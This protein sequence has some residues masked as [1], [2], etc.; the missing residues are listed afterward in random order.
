MTHVVICDLENLA[1]L[2]RQH[3][4]PF[5]I[6]ALNAWLAAQGVNERLAIGSDTAF[7]RDFAAPLKASGW[8]VRLAP[9]KHKMLSGHHS[10]NADAAICLE[11]GARVLEDDLKALTLITCDLALLVDIAWH[12]RTVEEIDIPIT[13]LAYPKFKAGR[14]PTDIPGIT[15]YQRLDILLTAEG[16]M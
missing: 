12:L 13:V 6:A 16:A 3:G 10:S 4:Y 1:Y 2:T 8:T 7:V 14:L 15:R 11:I 9:D 5:A